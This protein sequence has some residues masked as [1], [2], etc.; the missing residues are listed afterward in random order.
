MTTRTVDQIKKA[1]K[2]FRGRHLIR[3]I[4]L[5][6]E[7]D[8]FDDQKPTDPENQKAEKAFWAEW[9]VKGKQEPCRHKRTIEVDFTTVDN[10][11]QQI[12]CLNCRTII[13][14]MDKDE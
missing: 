5:E 13:N 4:A 10:D 8:L 11:P 1:L 12:V 3:K 7:I 9:D 2:P 6:L 14:K